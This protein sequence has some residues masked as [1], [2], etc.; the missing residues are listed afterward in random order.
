MADRSKISRYS[1]YLFMFIQ[2]KDCDLFM[3]IQ[4]KD[5]VSFSQETYFLLY[6]QNKYDSPFK[7]NANRG[8]PSYLTPD[9]PALIY[10]EYTLCIN[11]NCTIN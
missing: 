6:K 10:S 1:I 3:F 5:L 8:K 2:E 11:F 4:E 7:T 9:K